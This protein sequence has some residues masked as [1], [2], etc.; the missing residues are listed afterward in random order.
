MDELPERNYYRQF[1]VKGRHMRAEVLYRYAAG[2]ERESPEQVA[3]NM[4]LPSKPP[5]SAHE[6]W[7]PILTPTADHKPHE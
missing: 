4:I 1:W 6:D 3:R 5:V 7:I 2:L